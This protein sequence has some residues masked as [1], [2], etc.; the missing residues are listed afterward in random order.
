M[1]EGDK[2]EIIIVRRYDSEE[3]HHGNSTWKV[4]HADFMTAMM[5]FFLIMWLINATDEKARQEVANYFNPIRLADAQMNRKGLNDP[6]D[7]GAGG[8][9]E[10]GQKPTKGVRDLGPHPVTLGP[11]SGD[12]KAPDDAEVKR[13]DREKAVFRDPYAV[14]A[15]IAAE[16]E[17]NKDSTPASADVMVGETG[18][19]GTPGSEV[20]RDPFDP[21]YWQTAPAET[22]KPTDPTTTQ[23]AAQGAAPPP[24]DE[25]KFDATKTP[26]PPAQGSPAP[27]EALSLAALEAEAAEADATVAAA[28]AATAAANEEAAAAQASAAAASA[29]A[30]ELGEALKAVGQ[31]PHLEVVGTSDGILISLTDD[32]N[33]S[34]FAIGS[35]VPDP[36]AVLALEKI[37]KVLAE[38]SGEIIIR[39]H[40]DSRPF[41]SE[42][43][44][45]WRLSTARA[46]MA[47]YMLVRGGIDEKRVSKIEGFADRDPKD[48]NDP[49]A[50]IN[51][52]IEVI[53]REP[54]A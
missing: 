43:Y 13:G 39:G 46:H 24:P 22:K 35:A 2:Q 51:R 4:A 9:A 3:H 37:G 34:M 38:Q 47:Y 48:V 33:F 21:V 17:Q 30:A 12:E 26:S 36:Q 54:K 52:R 40:T 41:R 11:L 20:V 29:L 18:M 19:A 42:T 1:A 10:P 50:A 16:A 7:H 49:Q 25:A 45:N 28:A 8:A 27:A 15:E 6:Q 44:D 31:T 5:A 14:L 23:A 53:L 32:V